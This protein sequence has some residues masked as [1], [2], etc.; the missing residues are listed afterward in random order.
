MLML[1]AQMMIMMTMMMMVSV[2]LTRYFSQNS[3]NDQWT[4]F[5][6][7]WSI[8][9]GNRAP[10]GDALTCI[11]RQGPSMSLHTFLDF[12]MPRWCFRNDWL[13]STPSSAMELQCLT[14][15]GCHLCL[16]LSVPPSLTTLTDALPLLFT[17]QHCRT[18][19]LGN[20]P[21][22]ESE[23][24][25]SFWLYGTVCLHIINTPSVRS[26]EGSWPVGHRLVPFKVG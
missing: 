5:S 13:A 7:V 26:R 25:H 2:Q 10:A 1:A 24:A 12:T 20:K 21:T 22:A 9:K 14:D 11:Y 16:H 15:D 3:G 17:V 19:D 8:A 23:T 4:S 18:T 6:L